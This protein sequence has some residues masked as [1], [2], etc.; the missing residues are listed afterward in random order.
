MPTMAAYDEVT[1]LSES[2]PQ[3]GERTPLPYNRLPHL[4]PEV[5]VETLKTLK[6]AISANKALAELRTAGELI[7]NQALLIRAIVLQE[8]KLS[9]EIENIVTTNDE[10][11][12]AFGHDPERTDPATKEVL[13]Y[14]EALWH[15]YDRLEQGGLLTTRLFTEIA[16]IIKE[17]DTGVRKM[18]GTVVRT[19]P[20]GEPIYAPPEGEELLRRL[21][22]NLSEYLYSE[23]GTDPL[24]KMAVA[25]YQFEAIHP[26]PDG[27][28]RTGRVINILYLVA[29]GLLDVP[30]LYLS[31]FIIQNKGAYYEGLRRVTEEA[32]W[33]E[34]VL[35]M[36]DAVEQTSRD[37]KRRIE[38][39]RDAQAEAVELAR[40]QMRRGYSR[41]LVE[42]VFSQPYIRI[43]MLVES[44]VAKRDAA[45][46]Y[47]REL[48]R[49]GL[50]R[51]EK[52]GRTRFY[53]NERLLRI[54]A[55]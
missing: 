32:R 18:P 29:Q 45:S 23:D 49:I 12:R 41:E 51:S 35:F 17:H 52:Y 30:V 7:P 4:P 53:L 25:H 10:L 40:T 50:L 55:D 34:W 37:T 1:T 36:L 14:Q 16:S 20:P 46:E 33:E 47:L 27:N 42:L 21:L 28:G 13:R 8:A 43:G 19:R 39:I 15:G 48:E 24:I 31:R 54:L 5:A 11:Y 44:K 6:K 22:D 38:A 26:F 2:R 9:S 3:E